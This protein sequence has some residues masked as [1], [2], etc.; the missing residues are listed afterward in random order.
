MPWIDFSAVKKTV[1]IEMVLAHYNITLRKVNEVSLR[2]QCPLPTHDSQKGSPSFA[3]NLSKNAWA[4]LSQSCIKGRDGKRGGNQLD[5]VSCIEGC[6]VRDAALKLADWFNVS[7]E[8]G[9]ASPA[10]KVLAPDASKTQ[11]VAERK[12]EKEVTHV[13]VGSTENKPLGFALRHIDH[14]HPYLT[15]RGITPEIAAHFGIGFFGGKGS[16]HGRVVIPIHNRAGELVAYA[17]RSID[18]SEPKYKLPAGFLKTLELFNLHRVLAENPEQLKPVI[19]VEGFFGTIKVHQA[20]YHRVVALMGSSLSDAQEHMLAEFSHLVL[21]FDGDEAGREATRQSTS[22]LA[23]RTFV[24]V[25]NLADGIQ[26][27]QLSLEEI[28]STL[29]SI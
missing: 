26:P 27:D 1:S 12:S 17:G 6:S 8:G 18:E 24:K 4:C 5:L 16:M 15:A 19:V 9:G 20:G 29:G 10:V 7:S 3:V 14:S 21:M 11:P 28:K 2:G 23:Q 25:I 22:R 13:A